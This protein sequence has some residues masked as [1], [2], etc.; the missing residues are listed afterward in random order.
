MIQGLLG[1][2]LKVPYSQALQMTKYSQIKIQ[3]P[4]KCQIHGGPLRLFIKKL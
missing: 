4:Q 3:L 2:K 1:S